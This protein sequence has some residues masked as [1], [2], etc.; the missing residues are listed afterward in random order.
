MYRSVTAG[1]VLAGAVTVPST[2][3]SAEPAGA[4]AVIWV[5]EFTVNEVAAADPSTTAVAPV[6]P[7]PV[8]VTLV[9]PE[10]KPE[11]GLIA[12]GSHGMRSSRFAGS[13]V[14]VSAVCFQ[15]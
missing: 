11:D 8:M 15:S 5:A 4:V 6:N 9:P 13:V 10:N 7:L 12:N 2:G 14:P 1:L 3:P